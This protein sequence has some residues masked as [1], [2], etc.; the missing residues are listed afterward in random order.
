VIDIQNVT[1][2]LYPSGGGMANLSGF[3][4]QLKEERDWI[5]RQLSGLNAALAAFA[6]VYRGTPRNRR[7]KAARCQRSPERGSQRHREH[8]G[9]RSEQSGGAES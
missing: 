9:P 5:E 1:I 6:G 2:W 8:V 3:V 4:K 7:A